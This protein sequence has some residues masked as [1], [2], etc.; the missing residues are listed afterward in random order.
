MIKFVKGGPRYRL[1][2]AQATS[3]DILDQLSLQN[4]FFVVPTSPAAKL[5]TL[6]VSR[7]LKHHWR[8]SMPSH[9][10]QGYDVEN[11]TDAPAHILHD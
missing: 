10:R 11:V 8:I 2:Q 4:S 6:A 7:I 3:F 5:S 1:T 9:L